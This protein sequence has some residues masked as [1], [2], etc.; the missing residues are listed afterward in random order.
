VDD[1]VLPRLAPLV[2][3][4][5]AGKGESAL[6][7]RPIDALI[8]VGR[9]LAD[10]REQ[11]AEQGALVGG[12]VFRDLVDRGSGPV[13]VLGPDLDVTTAIERGGCPVVGR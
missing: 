9:V 6:D 7:R 2:S 12:Q 3:V 10:N 5:L 13:S 4:T 11:V 8:A 1:E